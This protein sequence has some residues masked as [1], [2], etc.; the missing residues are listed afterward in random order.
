[1]IGQKEII[2]L[3]SALALIGGAF[4][5][6]FHKGTISQIAQFEKDRVKLQTEVLD[7]ADDLREKNSELLRAQKEKE[8]LI[9]ELENQAMDAEGSSGPGVGTTGGLQRLEKRWGPSPRTP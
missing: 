1:M 3:V 6:G 8:G 5:Y 2:I 9:Y 4:A 7:L